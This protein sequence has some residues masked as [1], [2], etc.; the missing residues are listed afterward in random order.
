MKPNL[1]SGDGDGGGFQNYSESSDDGS[2]ATYDTSIW[3]AYTL[4]EALANDL[5]C[6]DCRAHYASW[7]QQN[8]LRI[9]FLPLNRMMRRDTNVGTVIVT[10]L[11]RLHNDV[12]SRLGKPTWSTQQVYDR[13]GG[14]RAAEGRD[15]LSNVQGIIGQKSYDLIM[16]LL[17]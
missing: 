9:S 6:P 14:N 2:I 15:A 5:P 13:Y 7:I 12:S 8:P 16:R 1:G 17:S 10:W 3:G 4:S 11:I